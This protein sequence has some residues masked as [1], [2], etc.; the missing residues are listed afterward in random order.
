PLVQVVLS[1]LFPQSVFPLS[2]LQASF[3]PFSFLQ[4]FS[5]PFSLTSLPFSSLVLASLLSLASLF[6]CFFLSPAACFHT[7]PLYLRLS[8]LQLPSF[9]SPLSPFSLFLLLSR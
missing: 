9:L 7:S 6:F 8:F 1:L 5:L 4:S 3:L 2:S